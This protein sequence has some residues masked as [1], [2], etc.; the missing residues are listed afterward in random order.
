MLSQ[1]AAAALINRR[2]RDGDAALLEVCVRAEAALRQA[3]KALLVSGL[4]SRD[5]GGNTTLLAY[6]QMR[7]DA[8]KAIEKIMGN[9]LHDPRRQP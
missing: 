9:A 8:M 3:H 4:S 2:M 1:L 7:V 6:A 5:S